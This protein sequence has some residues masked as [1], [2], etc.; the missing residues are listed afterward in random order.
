VRSLDDRTVSLL[1]ATSTPEALARYDWEVA[2]GRPAYDPPL[3]LPP[4]AHVRR[5]AN[6]RC[7]L[8]IVV[9]CAHGTSKRYCGDGCRVAARYWRRRE[10]VT[11]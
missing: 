9:W 5:C 1:L 3:D 2:G 10:A 6:P 7:G 11:R 8:P 4:R